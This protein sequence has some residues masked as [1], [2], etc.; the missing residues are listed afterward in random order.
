MVPYQ[1]LVLLNSS[2]SATGD[3]YPVTAMFAVKGVTE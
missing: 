3:V 1:K 2:I